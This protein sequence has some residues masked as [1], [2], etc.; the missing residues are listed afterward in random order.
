MFT[1]SPPCLDI[2]SYNVRVTQGYEFLTFV[3]E[4]F[5]HRLQLKVLFDFSLTC[6]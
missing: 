4:T 1:D 5:F 3:V 2:F 6:V